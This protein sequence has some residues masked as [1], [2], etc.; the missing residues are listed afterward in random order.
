MSVV[1]MLRRVAVLCKLMERPPR[2][3]WILLWRPAAREILQAPLELPRRRDP[4]CGD[5][6]GVGAG[7]SA[8]RVL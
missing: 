3:R 2:G 8:R 5:H 7:A 6:T 1:G 4:A